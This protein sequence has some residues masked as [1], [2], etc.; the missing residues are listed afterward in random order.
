MDFQVSTHFGYGFSYFILRSLILSFIEFLRKKRE[1]ERETD[2]NGRKSARRAAPFHTIQDGQWARFSSLI[3]TF[4]HFLSSFSCI[5]FHIFCFHLLGVV[6]ISGFLLDS[7]N[8][9]A[10]KKRKEKK[11]FES[12]FWERKREAVYLYLAALRENFC[13]WGYEK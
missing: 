12:G 7:E 1:R 11:V 9:K 4:L 13:E 6:R 10:D 5:F 2:R 8:Q 3:G